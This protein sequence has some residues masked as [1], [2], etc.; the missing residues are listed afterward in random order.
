MLEP[1]EPPAR[2]P[3]SADEPRSPAVGRSS[4]VTVRRVPVE[5]RRFEVAR[6]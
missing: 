3:T 5:T 6:G 2:T 4:A 1:I